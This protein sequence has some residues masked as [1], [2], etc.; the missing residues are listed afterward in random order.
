MIVASW[1]ALSRRQRAR[2][3]LLIQAQSLPPPL[4][5]ARICNRS[6]FSSSSP[7][8][9]PSSAW[10][11]RVFGP[12]IGRLVRTRHIPLQRRLTLPAVLT[13]PV[14]QSATAGSETSKSDRKTTTEA[15]DQ[16]PCTQAL[17]HWNLR[18]CS[19]NRP[20][21]LGLFW[22]STDD[23]SAADRVALTAPPGETDSASVWWELTERES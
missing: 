11:G 17:Q 23:T 2:R 14:R 1:R 12:S 18:P 6:L 16:R 13:T 10:S 21:L 3:Q 8:L 5:I 15:A 4:S 7:V 20:L 19:L 22:R 9:V